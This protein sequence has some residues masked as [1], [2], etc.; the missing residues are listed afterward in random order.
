MVD[1]LDLLTEDA[2]DEIVHAV[3]DALAAEIEDVEE[4]AVRD[5]FA[6]GRA[7]VGFTE[8]GELFVGFD[9][10]AVAPESGGAPAVVLPDPVEE[11]WL[12]ELG[13]VARAATMEPDPGAVPAR[14]DGADDD[15]DEREDPGETD[16]PENGSD[17]EGE[18]SPTPEPEPSPDP[19]PEPAPAPPSEVN[20]A[21][22][23]CV[24]LTFDDGPSSTH[25]PRLLDILAAEGVAATFYV[26]G[27]QVNAYPS[28]VA[29]Q[30]TEGHQVGNHTHSH[31]RL[32]SVGPDQVR[33]EFASTND[34]IEAATGLRPSTMRPPYGATDDGVLGIAGE[35]GLAQVLW[36][37]DTRD[38]EHQNPVTTLEIVQ[39]ETSAGSII[40]LHDVHA[41][42]VDAVPDLISWL[43]GQGYAMVTVNE[44][45]GD[46]GP[47][48]SVRRQ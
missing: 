13:E 12:T 15:A 1:A 35:E 24:A 34:A 43:R 2:H 8:D 19:D 27:S 18:P 5:E 40:L 31:P 7:R 28:I 16:E 46:L 4:E 9:E 45:V 36:D 29:R 44:L 38:W 23:P 30:I 42:T 6:A 39:Q 14:P 21:V 11:G 26:T 3:A 25:T 47:G 20:C 17:E 10:Y 41:A 32:L 33:E 37:V 22:D 48:Q